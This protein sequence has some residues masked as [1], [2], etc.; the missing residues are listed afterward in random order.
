MFFIDPSSPFLFVSSAGKK[1][2]EKTKTK[3]LRGESQSFPG[4]KR[5]ARQGEEK[6]KNFPAHRRR[7]FEAARCA[8]PGPLM[9]FIDPQ[10]RRD[11]SKSAS[12]FEIGPD[13]SLSF[14]VPPVSMLTHR[15]EEKN[16]LLQRD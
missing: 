8:I 9:S 13:G 16:V 1:E 5:G 10:T 2:G 15:T 7:H 11:K 6:K 14:L 12:P 3:K 4:K